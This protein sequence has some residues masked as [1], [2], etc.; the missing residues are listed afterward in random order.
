AGLRFESEQDA[1]YPLQPSPTADFKDSR[2]WLY[3]ILP[4]ARRPVGLQAQSQKAARNEARQ[5]DQTQSV[6]PSVRERWDSDQNYRPSNL[7]EYFTLT[8]DPR[9][10]MP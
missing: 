9:A 8:A 5:L 10:E 2:T 6:H 7:R 1:P 4:G 3:Q